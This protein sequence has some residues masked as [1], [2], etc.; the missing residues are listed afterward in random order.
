MSS[1]WT[2]PRAL[3]IASKKQASKINNSEVKAHEVCT[4]RYSQT[5]VDLRILLEIGERIVG[6]SSY[7]KPWPDSEWV[8]RSGVEPDHVGSRTL[9]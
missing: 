1:S 9:V 4:E 8:N 5:V 6:D 2:F 7:W 3:E